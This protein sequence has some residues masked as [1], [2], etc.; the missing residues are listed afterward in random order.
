[1]NVPEHTPGKTPA[2]TLSTEP[3]Q[4][5]ECDAIELPP[6]TGSVRRLRPGQSMAWGWWLVTAGVAVAALVAGLLLRRFLLP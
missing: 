4:F 2:E 1:M 5:F 3:V 6:D